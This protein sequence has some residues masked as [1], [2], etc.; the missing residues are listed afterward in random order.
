MAPTLAS[1]TSASATPASATPASATPASSTPAIAISNLVHCYGARRALAGINLEI[2]PGELFCVLGPNGSGKSTLF[3]LLSTLVT[4]Q[5]GTISVFGVDLAHQPRRV[6]PWLGVVFQSPSPDRKLTV[7]ENLTHQ[8]RHYGLSGRALAARQAEVLARLGIADR[9]HDRVEALSGGLRRRVELAKCLL[10]RPRLLLLDEPST[11]LDPNAR[12]DLGGWLASLAKDEG[13]TVVLTTHL[14]DEAER[15]DR[16]AIFHEGSIVAL[17]TAEALKATIGGDTLSITA[18]QPQ[19]LAADIASR[20]GS[21]CRVVDGEVRLERHAAHRLLAE[22][23]E[24]FADQI[25]DVRLGKPTLEDVFIAKTG[26]RF[27]QEAAA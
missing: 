12:S 20:F 3:R 16:L 10:H 11:G 26:H 4:V 8:G 5:Q 25:I 19:R 18:R 17:G 24:A 22:I 15:A 1:P 13:T 6:R 7:S 14:L 21:N 2:A 9:A 23:V 27:W